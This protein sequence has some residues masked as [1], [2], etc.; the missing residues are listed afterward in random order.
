MVPIHE[1]RNAP[2][3]GHQLAQQFEFLAAH[4]AHEACYAGQV[5]A[6]AREA[7][8]QTGRHRVGA[9]PEHDRN[10][11]REAGALRA[12]D[13]RREYHIDRLADEPCDDLFG[14]L[15]TEGIKGPQVPAPRSSHVRPGLF[16]QGRDES[17]AGG[18]GREQDAE[19][20][21]ARRRAGCQPARE[22]SEAGTD[23]GASV[24]R[25]STPED[26]PAQRPDRAP[27]RARSL[28]LPQPTRHTFNMLVPP[29]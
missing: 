6:G 23:G 28:C 8:H 22:R 2:R 3:L 12:D 1:Q 29:G 11:R 9:H 7:A 5:A 25:G 27:H 15:S 19:L 18:V 16:A 24:H 17:G 20:A 21:Q 14:R 13:T 26:Q 10:R 4:L